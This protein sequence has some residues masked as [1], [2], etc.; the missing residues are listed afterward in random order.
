MNFL[1]HRFHFEDERLELKKDVTEFT[2][3]CSVG[4]T[5]W[6]PLSWTLSPGPSSPL[7]PLPW[8]LLNFS[9][10]VLDLT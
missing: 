9:A 5:T 8:T 4:A 1:G 3:S 6:D 10:V 7:D 2:Q